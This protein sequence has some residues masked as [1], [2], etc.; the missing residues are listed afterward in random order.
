V[1]D[2]DYQPEILSFGPIKFLRGRRQGRY[3]Y[4]HSIIIDDEAMAV[5]DPSADKEH[6]RRLAQAPNLAA[7]FVSHFHEDHQK[8]LYLFPDTLVWVPAADAAAFTS[9]AGVFSLLGID[10]PEYSEYWQKTLVEE[11]HYRPLPKVQTYTDGEEL[12][13]GRTRVQVVHTPGHTPGH[14]CFYFPEQDILYLADLDLT[15]FGPWYGDLTSDINAL[16]ESLQLLEKFQAGVYLTGHGQGVFTG[17]EA[18]AALVQFKQV[19]FDREKEVLRLLQKP[20]T[21]FELVKRRLIYR[22]F[23]EPKFVYDHIEKQMISKHLA[24]L[25]QNGM[26]KLMEDGYVAA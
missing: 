21:I 3:P 6:C 2:N 15:S 22:K 5:I 8:Y 23:L 26:V 24:R 10:D 11:F 20:R 16:L 14:S 17:P 19:I 18:R 12:V 7:V 25:V 13:L 9:M 1:A 4:C